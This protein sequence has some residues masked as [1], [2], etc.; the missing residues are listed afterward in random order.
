MTVT[1]THRVSGP[2]A[3]DGTTATFSFDFKVFRAADLQV[4]YGAAGAVTQTVLELNTDYSVRLNEDQDENPGGSVALKAA[5]ESGLNLSITSAMPATQ[6]MQLTNQGGFYPT[7]I[8]DECDKLTILIQ[9]LAEKSKRS[10]QLPPTSTMTPEELT[11]KLL[12]AADDAT[13]VAKG[14]AEAAKQSASEAA[15][16]EAN[17][18]ASAEAAAKTL[19]EAEATITAKA[20]SEIGRVVEATDG[21]IKRIE[22]A[23]DNEILKQGLGNMEQV[24]TLE[25]DLASGGALTLP[26]G[27]T[28]LVGRHHLRLAWNGLLLYPGRQFE[29]VGDSDTASSSVRVLMPMQAGDELDA[30]VGVLGTG[31]VNEAIVTATEAR[32][33]VADLS[34]RVVYKNKESAGK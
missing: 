8:N 16:S 32:D 9:Q 28:Y 29:E 23:G 26:N 12:D 6:E 5:P 3:C 27:L 2:Y 34:R 30:W 19:T 18:A 33:A 11:Q 13:V 15:T 1:A 22:A 25:A 21:Q 17:A 4:A 24:W 14:Y 10:I 7:V 31:N 20:D